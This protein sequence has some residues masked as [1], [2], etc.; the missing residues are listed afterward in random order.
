MTNAGN[1]MKEYLEATAHIGRPMDGGIEA[2]WERIEDEGNGL[3]KPIRLPWPDTN[4]SL[5][6]G[7]TPGEVTI[8]AGS[9]GVAK[10]YLLLNILRYAG[11][12]NG[13]HRWKLLPMEDDAGRWIQRMLA[14]HCCSW[15]IVAQPENDT[16]EEMRRVAD[17]KLA[18]LEKHKELVAQWKM[19]IFENPRLP[20]ADGSGKL[21]VHDVHYQDVLMFLED[22]AGVFELVGLDC[23]SQITFSDN[24]RDYVGQGEFMR[25]V[26]S[27]AASTGAHIVLVG[28][29]AKGGPSGGGRDSLDRI[30]GSALFNRLAHNVITLTRHGPGAIESEIIPKSTGGPM[31]VEHRLTLAIEKCRGGMSGDRIA[32]DLDPGGPQFIEHGI[33]KS[34]S[35]NSSKATAT[36]KGRTTAKALESSDTD[37]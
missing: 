27:I 23:L 36:A 35:N 11:G 20:V 29:H 37:F 24:G 16:R 21:A 33:I 10:S 7:L 8:I 25:G 3:I 18:A 22:V 4:R 31:A 5:G 34:T 32:M 15:A 13:V 19:S 26:V 28:H 30:Q 1:K 12:E 14:V 17:V 9:A 2:L 6:H